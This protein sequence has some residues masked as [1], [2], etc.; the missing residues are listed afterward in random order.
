[1]QLPET[2]WLYP[3][4][5]RARS[6]R[7][8]NK[9]RL[10]QLEIGGNWPPAM[11]VGSFRT[12]LRR[13]RTGCGNIVKGSRFACHLAGRRASFSCSCAR[14]FPQPR[15]AAPNSPHCACR[16]SVLCGGNRGEY[17]MSN[18]V[19]SFVEELPAL[20]RARGDA[21]V[22][23]DAADFQ[24]CACLST[25]GRANSRRTSRPTITV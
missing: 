2:V 23:A 13:L 11:G 3:V 9:R 19:Q 21:H 17:P 5:L 12:I 8:G 4:K 7:L 24:W 16:L 22:V 20:R 15:L 14:S 6:R 18:V 1:M 10:G 25:S